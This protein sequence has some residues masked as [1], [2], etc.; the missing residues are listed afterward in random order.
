MPQ[1][2]SGSEAPWRSGEP[3]LR[4]GEHRRYDIDAH[5]LDTCTRDREGDPPRSNAQLEHRTP[6]SF[7]EIDVVADIVSPSPV[8]LIVVAT[9]VVVRRLL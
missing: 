4:A 9:V 5:D 6:E 8:R 2:D 1:L 7:R 3:V